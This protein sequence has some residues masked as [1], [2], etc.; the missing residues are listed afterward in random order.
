LHSV[1]QSLEKEAGT[2]SV[3]LSWKIN[4]GIP[5]RVIGDSIKLR[6]IL[7]NLLLNGI[8]HIENEGT[9][10]DITVSGKAH[11]ESDRKD[12]LK[13]EYTNWLHPNDGQTHVSGDVQMGEEIFVLEFHIQDAGSGTSAE[14]LESVLNPSPDSSDVKHNR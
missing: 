2:K 7:R 9:N 10:I 4:Q 11:S 14:R 6:Q 12:W 1:L 8:K 3:S 5:D 13:A